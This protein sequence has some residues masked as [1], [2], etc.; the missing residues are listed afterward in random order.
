MNLKDGDMGA[1]SG[2]N[3]ENAS[4]FKENEWLS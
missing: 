4:G 2:A 1:M 3:S